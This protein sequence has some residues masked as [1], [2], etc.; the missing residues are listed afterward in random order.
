MGHI[1]QHLDL[2]GEMKMKTNIELQRDVMEELAWEPSIDA[3][4]IG[5][6]TEDGIVTLSGGVKSFPEKWAAERAAQR[7]SGVRAVTD[8][9]VVTL[10]GDRHQSDTDI[11]RAAANSL[12]WNVS[13]PRDRVKV[14][15]KDGFITLDGNV[16]FYY[17]KAAAEAAVRHL[18]GVRD[19][20][21]QLSVKPVVMAADVKSKIEKALERAAEVDA[22]K[23]SVEAHNHRVILR[24]KVRTWVERE[25]AER[26]AWSAPGVSDV[27]NDIRI[28][29]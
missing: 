10:P 20:Y 4:S 12:N 26:A 24:G 2:Q 1:S 17:Q 23:I 16:D 18:T 3:A 22:Q 8:Q 21:N 25:E 5:V 9:I 13:V 7:V 14:L 11:A 15:V 29:A 6:S 19:V 28:A 27:Q